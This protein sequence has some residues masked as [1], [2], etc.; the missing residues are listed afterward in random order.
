MIYNEMFLKRNIPFNKQVSRKNIVEDAL[1]YLVKKKAQKNLKKTLKVTFKGEQGIDEGGLTKEF[2]QL[3]CQQLFDLKYGM[4]E[5]KN[6]S[7]LWFK[8]G[9]ISSNLNYELIGI[10]LG[11]ALY[12]KTLLDLHFPKVLYKKLVLDA[13]KHRGLSPTPSQQLS[14]RDLEQLD[15]Q[16]YSTL[17]NIL[18]LDFAKNPDTGVTFQISYTCWDAARVHDLVPNGCEISVTN[19]NKARFV[20][21][22]LEWY[23]CVSVEQ[24]YRP[25]AVGFFKV[26]AGSLIY[27]FEGDELMRAI[28]GQENLDFKELR[29][30]TKYQDGYTEGSVTVKHF[31]RVLLEDFNEE[32]KSKF[33]RFLTGN[34]R[35]PLRGLSAIRMVIS[36]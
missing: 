19:E 7:F 22:Y 5:N 11:L 20:E 26:L 17:T 32:D 35:A 23:L 16:V 13:L 33:L 9:S 10:M 24:Q 18:K 1:T 8:L 12:N 2:F 25:F 6:D 34:D 4:F 28:C 29:E 36:R 21:K 27:L 14:L 30:G 3:I 31:W 15:P